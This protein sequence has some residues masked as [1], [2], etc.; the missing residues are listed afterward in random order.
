MSL[1]DL[2]KVAQDIASQD[3]RSTANPLYCIYDI[4]Y[5]VIDNEYSSRFDTQEVWVS[6]E[7]CI[8]SES[9]QEFNALNALCDGD[10]ITVNGTRYNK[11][12]HSK[13]P[14]FVTAC[15]TE[16]GANA[17]LKANGHN[18]NEPYIYVHSLNR[19]EEMIGL[20]DFITDT[21]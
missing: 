3:N 9:D 17:Y 6:D 13:I 4:E 10:E 20:R 15:L 14:R 21:F 2:K 5:A 11:L 7:G 19:N 8:L 1:I 16:V 12:T 18:L